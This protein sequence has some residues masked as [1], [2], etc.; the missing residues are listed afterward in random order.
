MPVT[1]ATATTKPQEHRSAAMDPT[2]EFEFDTM[3]LDYMCSK[4]ILETVTKR[5][6]ELAGRPPPEET[7]ILTLF[8]SAVDP[9]PSH[10]NKKKG[11]SFFLSSM[12]SMENTL[13]DKARRQTNIA[14]FAGQTAADHRRGLVCLSVS[15]QPT[16]GRSATARPAE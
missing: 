2:T 9:I 6:E 3:I 10:Y 15:Q 14:R 8:D 7:N 13:I 16:L 12:Y 11:G 4:A 5:A 1:A